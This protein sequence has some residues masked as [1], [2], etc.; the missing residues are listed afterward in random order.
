MQLFVENVFLIH[1]NITTVGEMNLIMVIV[2]SRLMLS[3]SKRPEDNISSSITEV[4][5]G[6]KWSHQAAST[7]ILIVFQLN[8]VRRDLSESSEFQKRY[9]EIVIDLKREMAERDRKHKEDMERMAK[10]QEEIRRAERGDFR[11]N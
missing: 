8:R 10:E 5:P 1:Y 2:N 4:W 9:A 6:P 11:A 7:V 3:D